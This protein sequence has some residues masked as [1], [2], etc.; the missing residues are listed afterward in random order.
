MTPEERTEAA[1]WIIRSTLFV[2][3]EAV[4]KAATARDPAELVDPKLVALLRNAAGRIDR[5][6]AAI[7]DAQAPRVAVGGH[8]WAIAV[9]DPFKQDTV[10]LRAN[11][12]WDI[13]NTG[14]V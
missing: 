6:Q 8:M 2:V 7:V 3:A 5:A 10:A 1:R 13:E 4:A 9:A 12:Q 14:G 11:A